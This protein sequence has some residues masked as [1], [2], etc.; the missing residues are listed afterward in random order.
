MKS[1]HRILDIIETLGSV[2]SAGIRE[3]SALTGLP[4]AT[5]HRMAG[6]LV[7]RRFLKQDP[8][9]KRLSLSVKFLELGTRVQR[10]FNLNALAR[11]HL[12]T[13]MRE[14]RESVNLALQDGDEVVYLDRIQ[15]THSLLQSFTLPGARVPL[16]CTGVGK[17]FLSTWSM[18]EVEDYLRRNRLL[19]NTPRTIVTRERFIEE[20]SRIR[21][22]G[23]SVDD[24]EMEEGVRC[25]ASLVF[26]HAG[27]A[28]AAVSIS[29][30]AMRV[31]PERLAELGACVAGAARRI[32]A[33]LGYEGPPGL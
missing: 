9:T 15:S 28:V 13:L 20:L 8:A 32:S 29:G 25:L 6:P 14:T 5:I 24:E 7:Q 22:Q 18:E 12:E 33:E 17:A 4:P 30:A 31:T 10:Q 11:P 2:G 19:P 26:D 27:R 23:Y 3:L 21:N 16:Y 1:L